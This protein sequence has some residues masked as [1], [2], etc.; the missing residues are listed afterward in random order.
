MKNLLYAGGLI[1]LVACGPNTSQNTV[2]RE[3][4][5]ADT[6][7][8]VVNFQ[9][10]VVVTPLSGYFVKNTVKQSDSIACWVINDAQEMKDVFGMAKTVSNTIDTVDFSSHLLTAVTLRLSSLEQKIE[11]SSSKQD[12]NTVE[13]H[14]IIMEEGEPRSFTS[15]MAWL[16]AIPKTGVK[17]VKFYKGDQLIKR[18][19]VS[20]ENR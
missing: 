12:G 18:V 19:D 4:E 7:N 20:D 5:Q 3:E 8:E 9:K 2:T 10:D 1:L 14:F 15:A 16:G 17:T 11:L 13:L 6:T